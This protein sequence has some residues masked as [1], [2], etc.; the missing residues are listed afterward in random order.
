MCPLSLQNCELTHYTFPVTFHSEQRT[1]YLLFWEHTIGQDSFVSTYPFAL[2]H[3]DLTAQLVCDYSRVDGGFA[4]QRGLKHSK[5]ITHSYSG[6]HLNMV[7][8]FRFVIT[9]G[10]DPYLT[11]DIG[12]L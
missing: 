2:K 3:A 4:Q 1:K 11:H 9:C 5:A 10:Q 8:G 7:G 6:T 12:T